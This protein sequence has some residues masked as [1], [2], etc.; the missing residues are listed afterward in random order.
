M[1]GTRL[2]AGPLDAHLRTIQINT[3]FATIAVLSSDSMQ[4]MRT[5]LVPNNCNSVTR[6]IY[7]EN[8]IIQTI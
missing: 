8:V 3:S 6:F 1:A 7:S 5:K 4:M 2:S